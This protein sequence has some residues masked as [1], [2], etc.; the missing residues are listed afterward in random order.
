MPVYQY[1]GLAN[2][3]TTFN[4]SL[5]QIR[6]VRFNTFLSGFQLPWPPSYCLNLVIYFIACCHFGCL[7]YFQLLCFL[8]I[9]L[10]TI[11][12]LV[13]IIQINPKFLEFLTHS[14]FVDYVH[15]LSTASSYN[16][17]AVLRDIST[18]TSYQVVRLVF[19][20]YTHFSSSN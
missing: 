9:M 18:G 14:E 13:K 16:S 6:Q 5:S 20:P 15:I 19:R 1:I 11:C 17:T 7:S 10:T 12:P 3:I 2:D 8:Q 4:F